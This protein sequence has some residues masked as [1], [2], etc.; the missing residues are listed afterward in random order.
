MKQQHIS[1]SSEEIIELIMCYI[2]E[3]VS[4]DEAVFVCQDRSR[5][6]GDRLR[7]VPAQESYECR[8]VPGY[9]TPESWGLMPLGGTPGQKM[10]SETAYLLA[11]HVDYQI[12][13]NPTTRIRWRGSYYQYEIGP[14]IMDHGHPKLYELRLRSHNS[15]VPVS[16]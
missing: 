3:N 9:V 6:G 15:L 13:K 5:A 12:I 14:V 7:G 16:R 11:E 10:G 1:L 4:P 8:Q 2:G